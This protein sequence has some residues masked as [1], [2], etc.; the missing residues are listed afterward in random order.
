MT[1]IYL[2][3][4]GILNKS[5]IKSI[6]NKRGEIMELRVLQ[7]FLTIAREKTISK[8][9]EKLHLTQP[10]LS[11]Q[12]KDLEEE[13]GKQLF[14]RGNRTIILTEEGELLRKR[15]EEILSLVDKTKNELSI[16]DT[17]LKGDIYIG[18]GETEGMRIV[19]KAITIMQ[20]RYPLVRFHLFS[21]NAEDVASKLDKG[22]LDFGIMIDPVDVSQYDFL[23]LPTKD[24]WGI[25]MKKDDPLSVHKS[26][27]PDILRTLPIISSSQELVK[28]EI[29][30]WLGGNKRKLNIVSTYNLLYNASLMVEEGNAYALCLANIIN[31][32]GD[33]SL[34]FKPLNPKLEVGINIVWKKYHLFSKVSEQF[35][36]ILQEEIETYRNTKTDML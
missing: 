25:L 9:A 32:S 35:L 15:A 27:T 34:C 20:Q 28:N 10:T 36:K 30:G 7:Y 8:A 16:S 4:I 21:G 29:A 26:I 2:Y 24:I 31:T 17:S 6:I 23:K 1:I 19:S 33:S 22:L 5:I 14:V 18:A 12:I 11:R 3:L 13:V